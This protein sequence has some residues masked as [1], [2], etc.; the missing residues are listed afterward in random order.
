VSG[1]DWVA[2]ELAAWE[3][4]GLLRTP[5]VVTTASAPEV[6]IDGRAVVLLCS[7]NY[8]GLAD[9][10]RVRSAA[11]VAAQRWGAGSGASRLVSGTS[12][13]HRDLERELAAFEGAEDAVLFSSGYLANIGVLSTVTRAEDAV[14]SDELNHASIV[15]GCRL[16]KAH[17]E[18][19]RH[20]D[21]DHLDSLL[22]ASHAR[23]RVVV[24]DT[25]FSMDGDLAPLVGLVDLCGRHDAVLVVDEAHATGVLGPRGAGAVDELGL[26]G[27]V[28]VVVGTL[29]K[30][31]GSAGGYVATTRALATLLRNRARSHVFDTA[32]AP[33]TIAAAQAALRIVGAEPGR[34]ERVRALARRVAA[35]LRSLNYEAGEPA[36]AVVPVLVGGA[37]DAV[38][39]SERLL[40]R[41]VFC[42]AIRPPS[43][44]EGTSRLRV[45]LMATHTDEHIERALEAFAGA[46]AVHRARSAHAT[47][48]RATRATRSVFVTGT[49]TGVGKTIVTAAIARALAA[50]GLRV[51]IFKP[52]QTGTIDGDDDAREAARL[53]GCDA[54]TGVALPDPL[55]P[56]V[57]ADLVGAEIDLDAIRDRFHELESSYDTVIVE[58]AGGVLVPIDGE[59]TMADLA[60]DLG[61]PVVVVARPALGTLNHTALTV[62]AARSRGVDVVG[63]VISGF[64]SEPSLA[65]RTNPAELERVCGA[66]LAGAIP[67][68]APPLE[69]GAFDT[70][71]RWVAPALGGTFDRAGFLDGLR[72]E[73]TV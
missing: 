31:L 66:P 22:R 14:F 60:R 34:R 11:A 9:D 59:T 63:I 51:A 10:P 18:V 25:V 6:E 4:A 23:R 67:L 30:A 3:D 57:A 28:P 26:S 50:T 72:L 43:V 46:T 39:L 17:V 8:L 61:L 65:E 40:E 52:L 20:A 15:D 16:S 13:L 56:S 24:T 36:A 1:L 38:A 2:A 35:E 48:R 7:N 58:G 29:S 32:P 64:P 47:D 12:G 44:P 54:F 73:A 41:G 49:D 62:E 68:I 53:S 45:T 69:P 37:R 19:Y 71:A 27:R 5:Q 55:A 21:V 70:A 33:S 42:P